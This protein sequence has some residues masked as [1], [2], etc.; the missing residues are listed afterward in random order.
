MKEM[1]A[2]F[3]R[4]EKDDKDERDQK[5]EEDEDDETDDDVR[6]TEQQTTKYKL[7]HRHLTEMVDV[8]TWN[9]KYGRQRVGP[10]TLSSVV[11]ISD[12]RR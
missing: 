4:A 5:N 9:E 7:G 11:L 1:T 3:R 8:N 6:P 2:K 10:G 12:G